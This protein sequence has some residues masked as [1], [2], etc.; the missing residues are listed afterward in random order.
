[1][2]SYVATLAL[3]L[4]VLSGIAAPLTPALKADDVA[5]VSD[6]HFADLETRCRCCCQQCCCCGGHCGSDLWQ[7][8]RLFGDLLGPKSRLAERGIIADLQ[9]TQFYQGVT[10]GGEEQLFLYGGKMDYMFTFQGGKLGLNEGFSTILHAETR[11]GEAIEGQAGAFALPNTNMLWPLPVDHVTSITGLLFLQALNERLAMFA[12]KINV[13][14]FW[15]M[16][17]PNVSRGVDGFMNLNVLA[18]G[19]PWFRFVNLSVNGAG[20]LVMDGQQIQGGFVVFDTNNS[21]TTAGLSNLFDQGAVVLGLWRFFTDWNGKPGSHLFAG[22]YSNRTYTAFDGT[23]WLIIPGEGLVAPDET[24][25]WSLAYYFDQVLWADP[26]NEQRKL[27]LFTGASL[28]DE[29]PNFS[30]WNWYFS[31]EGF[32]LVRGRERD[33]MGIAYFYNQLTSG[34]KRTLNTLPSFNVQNVHGGEVYYNFAVTP[35]FH[36]TADLQVVDNEDADEDP[37]VIFGLRGNMKF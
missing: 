23:P 8:E 13:A 2:K 15:T 16:F 3:S 34:V 22:G 11:F 35:W 9:L 30:R 29:S 32:G 21:S 1:M 6:S 17:Y 18:A 20:G 33:R 10:G 25:A 36:L 31:V 24:G 28:S 27:Q 37:A 5:F 14:D 4:G 12:G 26:C 19:M 7:R